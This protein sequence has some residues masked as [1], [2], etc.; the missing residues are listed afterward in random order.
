[1]QIYRRE[2][3]LKITSLS[4]VCVFTFLVLLDGR[5][6]AGHL[7]GQAV[8]SAEGVAVP[9]NERPGLPVLQQIDGCKTEKGERTMGRK[10]REEEEE[11]GREQMWNVRVVYRI[12]TGREDKQK[13]EEEEE[14]RI[15]NQAEDNCHSH[16]TLF[17][18]EPIKF[19]AAG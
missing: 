11:M 18:F 17:C 6:R 3:E 8:G 14:R 7:H 1:M 10:K 15:H 5:R 9:Y 2:E 13:G 12:K 4:S 16:F 19:S